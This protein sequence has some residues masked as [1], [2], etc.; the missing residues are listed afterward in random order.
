MKFVFLLC[1][2]NRWVGIVFIIQE[3]SSYSRFRILG[4]EWK[5]PPCHLNPSLWRSWFSRAELSM[6]NHDCLE[7]LHVLSW[8]VRCGKRLIE[9][10]PGH[11]ARPPSK[12]PSSG[13]SG[14]LEPCKAIGA[15]CFRRQAGPS[16]FHSEPEPPTASLLLEL[17]WTSLAL[18]CSAAQPIEC[19]QIAPCSQL[20]SFLVRRHKGPPLVTCSCLWS[21]GVF[22]VCPALRD[23]DYSRLFGKAYRWETTSA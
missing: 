6:A 19:L 4:M 9:V 10:S 12:A 11:H 21:N 1:I 17:C 22:Q 8:Q 3:L 13:A 20:L 18:L 16:E 23:L 15:V 2:N 7:G 14:P 5:R